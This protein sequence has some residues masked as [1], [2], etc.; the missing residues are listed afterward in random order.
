MTEQPAAW[1]LAVTTERLTLR[2]HQPGDYAVWYAA[3]DARLPAQHAYDP[4]WSDMTEKTPDWFAGYCL[5]HQR[6]AQS[7]SVYIWGVFRNADG[8]HLGHVDIAT[9]G[10][11]AQWANLGY[12][13]HN[14]HWRQGYGKEAALAAARAGF[15]T[16]GCHRLEAVMNLENQASSALAAALGCR[17]EGIRRGFLYEDG[18]WIDHHVWALLPGDLGLPETAPPPE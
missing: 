2:P 18:A 9:I 13:I 5:R 3:L 6:R 14:Q 4:G 8:Q 12:N 11:Y 1:D 15:E 16:L 10:R 17:Y 7:D